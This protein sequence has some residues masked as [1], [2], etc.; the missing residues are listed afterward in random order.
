MNWSE[1]FKEIGIVGIIGVLITWLIKQL[2]QNMIDKNIRAYEL[3]LSN[4]S[5]LYKL[6]LNQSFEEFKAE[7]NLLSE[8]ANKLH[9]KRI[10]H[11]QNIY[12]LLIDFHSEMH[13]LISWKVVTGMTPKEIKD[14]EIK[15]VQEAG[16]SGNKF[17]MYYS[18]NKLFF[19]IETCELID[20]I[21]SLLKNSHTDFSFKY[22]FGAISAELEFENIR[23][24][25]QNI[26]DKVPKLKTKLEE[27]F[28]SIIGVD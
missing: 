23:N 28:R 19:N 7:L 11:I 1:I 22:I 13:N 16:D 2:G 5:D 4:K 15:R 20:E 12:S 27:N 24:A 25:G 3:E 18:K 26:R 8:K 21:I 17:F 10:E 14:N 9:D 6:E